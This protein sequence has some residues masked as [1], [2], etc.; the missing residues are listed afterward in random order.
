MMA[1]VTDQHVDR[2]RERAFLADET[3]DAAGLLFAECIVTGIGD[4]R[5]LL[6]AF[7]SAR[8]DANYAWCVYSDALDQA[9]RDAAGV[10][11]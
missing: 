9:D 7:R 11:A 4:P 6:H 8:A 2:A 1:P 3:A 5:Q 10:P